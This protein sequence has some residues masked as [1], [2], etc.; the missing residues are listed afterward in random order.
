MVN[1]GYWDQ[2]YLSG[3]TSGSGSYGRLGAYKAEFMNKFI[4]DNRIESVID[5]GCGDGN[6][7]SMLNQDIRYIGLDASNVALSKCIAKFGG[8]RGWQF[9]EYPPQGAMADLAMSLDVLFHIIEPR[10]FELY[11]EH[12]FRSAIRFV[13]I[14]SSDFDAVTSPHENRI[15][16]SMY[17]RE[18]FKD[19]CLAESIDNRFPYDPYN[20]DTTSHSKWFVYKKGD[21]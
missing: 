6:Q 9:Y 2:R 10:A 5:F 3:G 8:T 4:A 19:W 1:T 13:I 7:I 21:L 11:L 17:V 18:T 16:F 12:L 14:Y 20:P 15:S